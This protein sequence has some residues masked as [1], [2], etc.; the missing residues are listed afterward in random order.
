MVNGRSSVDGPKFFS[1]PPR[2]QPELPTGEFAIPGPPS[3]PGQN[4][5]LAL[6]TTMVPL[7]SILGY[8]LLASQNSN[9]LVVLPMG[10]VGIASGSIGF[11]N[12]RN[13]QRLDKERKEAYTSR[14]ESLKKELGEA[15]E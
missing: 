1:R 14:L 2:I 10:I 8:A 7:L 6:L 4:A 9:L 11:L 13:S 3:N 12:W 15:A 5:R